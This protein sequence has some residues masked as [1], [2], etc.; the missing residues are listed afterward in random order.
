MRKFVHG[1]DNMISTALM[2]YLHHALLQAS[3]YQEAFAEEKM[4]GSNIH[5]A[6]EG[7]EIGAAYFQ[8]RENLPQRKMVDQS[9]R[10]AGHPSTH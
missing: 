8:A 7:C 6:D 10:G 3:S 5:D 1:L 4:D 2:A 9:R